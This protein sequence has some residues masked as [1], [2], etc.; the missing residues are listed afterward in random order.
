MQKPSRNKL[1]TVKMEQS[2]KIMTLEDDPSEETATKGTHFI[3]NTMLQRLNY[4]LALLR[5]LYM[6]ITVDI[7]HTATFQS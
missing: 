3:R 7:F 2:K 6:R 4:T 5:P 1:D